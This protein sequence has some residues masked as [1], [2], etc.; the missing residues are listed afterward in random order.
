MN[1]LLNIIYLWFGLFYTLPIVNNYSDNNP[2]YQKLYLLIAVISL[3]VV[4]KF[5]SNVINKKRN[6]LVKLINNSIYKSLL[7]LL[8][9]LIYQDIK[10]SPNL[11]N[12]I[13]GLSNIIDNSWVEVSLLITPIFIAGTMECLLTPN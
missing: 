12:N 8:G 1:R 3:Q 9:F 6:K 2:I 10:L 7:V 13:P 5:L 4:F 11:T